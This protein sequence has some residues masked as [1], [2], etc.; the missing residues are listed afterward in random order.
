VA[1]LV[2]FSAEREGL[3]GTVTV[4]ARIDHGVV[5]RLLR[6]LAPLLGRFLDRKLR[7]QFSLAVRVAETAAQ[8]PGQ[9]CPLLGALAGGAPEERQ[10]LAG[11]AG[12]REGSGVSPPDGIG[13][14]G[15]P[16]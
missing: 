2:V 7:E 5:D 4:W 6:L 8:D 1:A 14:H 16:S 11:L 3:R 13:H 9:F 12:C 15:E 10:A